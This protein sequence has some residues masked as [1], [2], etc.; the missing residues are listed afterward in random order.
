M[1][2]SPCELSSRRAWLPCPRSYPSDYNANICGD[3]LDSMEGFPFYHK[4]GHM[5]EIK[6]I[7]GLRPLLSIKIIRLRLAML[8]V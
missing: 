2:Q 5:G 4:E 1:E 6:L 3:S 8:D 7:E